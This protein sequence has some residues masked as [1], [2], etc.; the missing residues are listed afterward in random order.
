MQYLVTTPDN[1]KDYTCW[2]LDEAMTKGRQLIEH[3]YKKTCIYKLKRTLIADCNT[4]WTLST[5][6]NKNDSLPII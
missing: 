2:S 6:E 5:P 4:H 1:E 3:G